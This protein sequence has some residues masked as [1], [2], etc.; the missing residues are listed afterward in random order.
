[1]KGQKI[2]THGS[3]RCELPGKIALTA[4]IVSL[5]ACGGGGGDTGLNL[6][7]LQDLPPSIGA[8]SDGDINAATD[9]VEVAAGSVVN[10]NILFNDS[11][12]EGAGLQLLGQPDNG[13]AIL[14]DTGEIQY[15]ANSD[16][17]GTDSVDYLLVAADGTE[18]VGTLFIACLLYTSDAADE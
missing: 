10:A 13:T 12:P 9:V 6:S 15:E 3:Y 4:A 5:T 7:N 16:F 14:L 1:M 17:E 11:I 8:A 18:S 2:R